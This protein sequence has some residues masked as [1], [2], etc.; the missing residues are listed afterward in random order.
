MKNLIDAKIF[1]NLSS[2]NVGY[3]VLNPCQVFM[4]DVTDETYIQLHT[5]SLKF[6][7]ISAEKLHQSYVSL[8]AVAVL[9]VYKES[10]IHSMNMKG[11]LKM[12]GCATL[13]TILLIFATMASMVFGECCGN[14]TPKFHNQGSVKIC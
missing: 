2:A 5:V 7:V 10:L 11:M 6:V 1:P 14:G 4:C 12:S 8:S 9:K 3:E 13:L